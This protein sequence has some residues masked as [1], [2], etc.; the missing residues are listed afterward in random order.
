MDWKEFFKKDI[1]AMDAGIVLEEVAPGSA[2]ATLKIEKRHLN[3]GGVAQGGAVFTLADLAMAA[4]VN[5]HGVLAFSIQS[6]IRYLISAREG[7]TLTAEAVEKLLARN[8]AHYHVDITDQKGQLI[9][10]FDGVCYRK[11]A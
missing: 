8:V 4:A 1:F 10:L 3:A 11:Q 2:K 5:A 9:A 6:D 7:D